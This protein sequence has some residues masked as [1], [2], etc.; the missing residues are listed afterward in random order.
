MATGTWSLQLLLVGLLLAGSPALGGV[1][2]PGGPMNIP[3]TD[4]E[5][6][7]AARVAVGAFNRDSDSPYIFQ[8]E[9]VISAQS[10]VVSGIKYYLTVEL[11]KTQCLKGAGGHSQTCAL[12]PTSQQQKL[13]CKFQVWS[14]PWLHD[15][16]VLSQ[17][18]VPAQA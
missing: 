14:R 9:K 1:P 2:M 15:T 16:R 18:C 11:E 12:P 5:V 10:Q 6:Q 17:S 13:M 7:E 3:V 8:A 4:A